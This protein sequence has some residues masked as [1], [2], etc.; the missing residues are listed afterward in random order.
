MNDSN[1][2]LRRRVWRIGLV[3]CGLL[4]AIIGA[5][6][7]GLITRSPLLWLTLGVLLQIALRQAALMTFQLLWPWREVRWRQQRGAARSQP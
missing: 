4:L 1:S 3:A 5:A 2:P 6:A 7:F